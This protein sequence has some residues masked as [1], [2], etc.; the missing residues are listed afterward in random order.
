MRGSFV[1]LLFVVALAIPVLALSVPAL[2][3]Y[4]PDGETDTTPEASFACDG[5]T[6]G[7]T[8]TCSVGGWQADTE[9]S[10]E[11]AAGETV[12]LA[13]SVTADGTGFISYAFDVPADAETVTFVHTGVLADGTPGNFTT[14]LEATG[15]AGGDASGAPD[16]QDGLASTGEMVSL[17]LLGGV[18]ALAVGVVAVRRGRTRQGTEA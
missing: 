1:R 5:L 3:Q 14:T 7:G 17:L 12:V 13:D 15:A 10:V 2:A 16:G 4:P 11:V 6:P 9:V 18:L 8:A